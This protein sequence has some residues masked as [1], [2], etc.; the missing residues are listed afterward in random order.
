MAISVDELLEEVKCYACLGLP[1]SDLLQL[2]LLNRIAESGGGGSGGALVY[3]ALLSQSG[4]NAPVATVLENTIGEIVWSYDGPG[5][6]NATLAGAFTVGKT[7]ILINTMA[8]ADTD[9][10][11]AA[12]QLSANAVLVSTSFDPAGGSKNDNVLNNT[13]IQILVYP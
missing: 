2:A 12:S 3:R 6:Y 9:T 1:L 5:N 10:S 11:A 7:C 4:A 8:E 13:F